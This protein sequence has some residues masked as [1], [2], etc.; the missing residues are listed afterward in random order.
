MGPTD[1]AI[2]DGKRHLGA[3]LAEL[4]AGAGL[5]Q[6]ELAL[7]IAYDRTTVAHAER[8][9]QI[10]AVEFWQA[11]DDRLGAGGQLVA[12]YRAWR[13]TKQLHRQQQRAAERRRRTMATDQPDAPAPVAAQPL[14]LPASAAIEAGLRAP[15]GSDSPATYAVRSL[16]AVIDGCR[17]LDHS[18]GPHGTLGIVKSQVDVATQ[19]VALADTAPRHVR[20]D[21]LGQLAELQQLAGWMR[22]DLGQIGEARS[23][24][25]R[26]RASA[27]EADDAMLVAF[28]LGPSAGFAELDSGRPAAGVEL[29]YAAQ[30]W[31]RRA[32][33]TRL[34]SFVLTIA[35]RAHAKLGEGRECLRLLDEAD[36]L[37][38]AHD[39]WAS[40][41][42]WLHVFDRSALLGHHGSCLLDLGR[43]EEAVVL[44]AEQDHASPDLFVR[45]RALWALDRAV[46]YR[47]AGDVDAATDV[48]AGTLGL[49]EVTTSSRTRR[50]LG[51]FV[52]SIAPYEGAPPVRD[53]LDRVRESALVS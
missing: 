40:D 5:A 38:A 3:A 8:G 1:D 46:A 23:M 20:S 28:V 53:L 49:L 22:F 21:A 27:I 48:A 7:A 17:G 4:R 14:G 33:N 37:L 6:G 35:G 36:G 43:P 13:S 41:P 12:A 10:P 9:R 24:F 52:K 30:G 29:A 50:R 44:L 26:A 2:S 51:Q 15:A 18:L 19:L 31:A 34:L 16:R 32:G 11:C 25:D 47:E 39:Q 42:V 45:N